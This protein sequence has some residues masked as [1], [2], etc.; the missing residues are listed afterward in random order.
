MFAGCCAMADGSLQQRNLMWRTCRR[1]VPARMNPTGRKAHSWLQ[2]SIDSCTMG[3]HFQET[4]ESR[5]YIGMDPDRSQMQKD[6][7][8]VPTLPT[9]ARSRG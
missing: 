7:A 4:L 3:T 5:R 9:P 1:P 6:R 2:I 8:T